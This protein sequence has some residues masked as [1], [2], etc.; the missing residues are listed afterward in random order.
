MFYGCEMYFSVVDE[1][2]VEVSFVNDLYYG[3]T[4]YE[5]LDF[6]HFFLWIVDV[7]LFL[8][9]FYGPWLFPSMLIK[10]LLFLKFCFKKLK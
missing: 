3:Y 1:C 6:G 2:I 7:A 10:V 8:S 9:V 4:C 5:V